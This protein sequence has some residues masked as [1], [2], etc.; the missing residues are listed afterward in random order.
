MNKLLFLIFL[1]FSPLATQAEPLV[2]GVNSDAENRRPKLVD[3]IKLALQ[4]TG[5]ELK[6]RSL[7]SPRLASEVSKGKIDIDIFRQEFAFENNDN[8]I[9]IPHPIDQRA[10]WLVTHPSKADLC[11]LEEKEYANYSV[12]G[13][14]GVFFFS[15]FVYPKFKWSTTTNTFNQINNL[16]T[17]D[18]VDFSVWERQLIKTSEQETG[19]PLMI[20]GDKPFISFRF[21]S[22]IQAKH[23]ALIP[24]IVAAYKVHFPLPQ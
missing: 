24:K 16:I 1:L 11:K 20:C 22:F 5:L 18:R 3:E 8:I 13:L 9:P 12:A 6:F 23:A 14:Q 4:D 17:F 10:F 2:V 21:Y 7:P 19:N 15:Q